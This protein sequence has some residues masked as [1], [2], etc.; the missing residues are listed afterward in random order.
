MKILLESKA[1]VN[2]QKMVSSFVLMMLHGKPCVTSSN[3]T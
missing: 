3:T 2:K 1:D